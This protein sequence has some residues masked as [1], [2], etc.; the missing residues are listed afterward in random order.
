MSMNA[1]AQAAAPFPYKAI[2]KDHVGRAQRLLELK[3][4]QFEGQPIQ[5]VKAHDLSDLMKAIRTEYNA[6]KSLDVTG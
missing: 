5:E 4:R 1:P 3:L 2:A 6:A